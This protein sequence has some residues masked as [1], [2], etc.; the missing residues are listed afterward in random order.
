[1]VG[2]EINWSAP[3]T[4]PILNHPLYQKYYQKSLASIDLAGVK[5]DLGLVIMDADSAPIVAYLC[6]LVRCKALQVG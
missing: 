4:D 2:Y 6:W 3:P 1:M 5:T